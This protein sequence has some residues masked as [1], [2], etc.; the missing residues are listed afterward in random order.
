MFQGRYG[1][2]KGQEYL[3]QFMVEYKMPGIKDWKVY[4]NRKGKEV[5]LTEDGIEE[6][7]SVFYYYF[8]MF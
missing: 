3:Q 8:C 7:I 1:K 5:R 4:A 6:A 2:G